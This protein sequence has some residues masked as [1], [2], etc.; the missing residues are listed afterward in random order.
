[1]I[2]GAGRQRPLAWSV[3]RILRRRVDMLLVAIRTEFVL[4]EEINECNNYSQYPAFSSNHSFLVVL[5]RR[6]GLG[7]G[8]ANPSI[9]TPSRNMT[10]G[11]HA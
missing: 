11:A 3:Q 2:F 4:R 5:L 6:L 10:L 9:H 8:W 1:M 7:D